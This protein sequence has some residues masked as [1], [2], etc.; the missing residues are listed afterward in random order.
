VKVSQ[1]ESVAYFDSI[2]LNHE[3]LSPVGS[4]AVSFNAAGIPAGGL[5][6]GQDR[7]IGSVASGGPSPGA[8]GA[9]QDAARSASSA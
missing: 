3:F 6:T 1:D 8:A 4:D 9:G 5:L 2:G 7:C